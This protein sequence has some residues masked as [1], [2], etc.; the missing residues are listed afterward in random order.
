M[1]L[2]TTNPPTPTRATTVRVATAVT[3]AAPA[4]MVGAAAAAETDPSGYPHLT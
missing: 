3:V 1:A 2:I 4:E